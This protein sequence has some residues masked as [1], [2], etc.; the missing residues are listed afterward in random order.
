MAYDYTGDSHRELVDKVHQL[1]DQI[2]EL[3]QKLQM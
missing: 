1:E 2:I 3:E